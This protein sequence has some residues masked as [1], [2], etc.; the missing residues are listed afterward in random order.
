[1]QLVILIVKLNFNLANKDELTIK[2]IFKLQENEI[3]IINS[4][5]GWYQVISETIDKHKKK[6]CELAKIEDVKNLNSMVKERIRLGEE[7]PN[8]SK[9]LLEKNNL[10]KEYFRTC[11]NHLQSLDY[12][13]SLLIKIQQKLTEIEENM[14]ISMQNLTKTENELKELEQEEKKMVESLKNF[15]ATLYDLL[16]QD[17]FSFKEYFDNTPYK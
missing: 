10:K 14:K 1:L 3:K 9:N 12:N 13:K 16:Y 2:L 7:R 15:D 17:E 6:I 5:K 4:T 8:I 11:S